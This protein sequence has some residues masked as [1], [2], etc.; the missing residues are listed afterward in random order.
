MYTPLDTLIMFDADIG[1]E[2][3]YSYEFAIISSP[4]CNLKVK[5]VAGFCFENLSYAYC[6]K[7]QTVSNATTSVSTASVSQFQML[8]TNYYPKIAW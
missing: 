2:F 7:C 3:Y 1:N 8:L 5:N 4:V 6:S